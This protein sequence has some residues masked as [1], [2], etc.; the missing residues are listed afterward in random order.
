MRFIVSSPC[1]SPGQTPNGRRLADT[2]AV[3]DR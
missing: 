1:W 2:V 3:A